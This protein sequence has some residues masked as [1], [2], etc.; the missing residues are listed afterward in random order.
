M[1]ED[2]EEVK[3]EPEETRRPPRNPFQYNAAL[4]REQSQTLLIGRDKQIKDISYLLDQLKI[5]QPGNNVVVVGERASGKTSLLNR[6]SMDAKD[7]G[8]FSVKITLDSKSADSD[9]SF[10][11]RVFEA[12]LEEA[13]D[14]GIL[15]DNPEFREAHRTAFAGENMPDALA[16]FLEYESAAILGK[17]SL[18]NERLQKDLGKFIEETG[19]C[20]V[21]LIDESQNLQGSSLILEQI[22]NFLGETNGCMLVLSGSEEFLETV[23]ETH[24]GLARTMRQIR[25]D[26]FEKW[27]DVQECVETFFGAIEGYDFTS[28]V[29]KKILLGSSDQD[30]LSKLSRDLYSATGVNHTKSCICAT[31]PLSYFNKEK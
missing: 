18:S 21:L 8:H 4:N 13:S 26:T 30:E 27:E 29:D 2:I 15:P 11:K 16:G 25:L 17:G 31:L 5:D 7:R 9:V 12:I 3:G 6:I 19:R 20:L 23:K 10:W 22:R 28:E 1:S 14:A 24:D